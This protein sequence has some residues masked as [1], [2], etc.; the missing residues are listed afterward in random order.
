MGVT[1]G[2]ARQPEEW[3]PTAG[4]SRGTRARIDV[5]GHAFGLRGTLAVRPMDRRDVSLPP[6]YLLAQMGWV[7]Q[8]ARSLLG[9]PYDAEDVAQEV[10]LAASARPP[11]SD[12]NPRAWLSVVTRHLVHSR[13]RAEARRRRRELKVARSGDE[14]RDDDVLARGETSQ[15]LATAVMALEEPYRS[16]VLRRYLDGLSAAEIAAHDGVTEAAV[17]KRLSRAMQQL[18]AQLDKEFEGGRVGWTNA[19]ITVCQG[20]GFELA[21]TVGTALGVFLIMKKVSIVVAAVAV[22]VCVFMFIPAARRWLG[23]DLN[24]G[25]GQA[26][27]ET[28]TA[29]PPTPFTDQGQLVAKDGT[30]ETLLSGPVPSQKS[31]VV[32]GVV[33]N[34][35]YPDPSR[36]PTPAAGVGVTASLRSS[37]PRP[38][39]SAQAQTGADGR[40][41]IELMDPGTRPLE[42]ALAAEGDADY[43]SGRS[44]LQI[45]L[46]TTFSD[47]R[48]ERAARGDLVGVVVDADE[49]PLGG[50][51]VQVGYSSGMSF[52]SESASEAKLNRPD[53]VATTDANGVFAF[54]NLHSAGGFGTP[55]LVGRKSGYRM[56]PMT[57]PS[58]LPKGGWNN[59]RITM[60][61]TGGRI[62]AHVHDDQG[63]PE[64]GA[65]LGITVSNAEPGA[66]WEPWRHEQKESRAHGVTG[67]N[68]RVA[69][70][71]IWIGV[72][73]ELSVGTD[74]ESWTFE[75]AMDGR[76]VA[77]QTE[78]GSPI[79]VPSS[80]SLDLEI[81]LPSHIRVRGRVVDAMGA[82]VPDANIRLSARAPQRDGM[83]SSQPFQCDGGG[84]FE[85]ELRRPSRK[86]AFE[87]NA[88]TGQ[89]RMGPL[90]SLPPEAGRMIGR[91]TMEVA[92][93]SPA[94]LLVLVELQPELTIS[95][96]AREAD[97]NACKGSIAAIPDGA[98]EGDYG[99][100]AARTIGVDGHFE[101]G[102][103]L[104]G[105][106]DLDVRP[107]KN[108]VLTDCLLSQRFSGIA[109]GRGGVELVLGEDQA[110]NVVLEVAPSDGVIGAMTVAT[111]RFYPFQPRESASHA[112][113]REKHFTG[114]SGW[115]P[116]ATLN[117][118]GQTGDINEEGLTS[119]LN[120]GGD[121]PIHRLKPMN[122]GWYSIG[123]D[124]TDAAG[125]HYHPCGTGLVYL[126][127]GSYHF[128]FDLV[129]QTHV[130]GRILNAEFKDDLCVGLVTRDGRAVQVLRTNRHLDEVV[131]IGAR[132]RFS[133]EGAPAG[134]FRLRFGSE[135]QLRAGE[136]DHEVPLAISSKENAPVLIQMP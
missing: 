100:G 92:P 28:A 35:G 48:L 113:D 59:A 112:P 131:S 102:G 78:I 43:R 30:R 82:A 68:G 80:S 4:S 75:R 128:R 104:P 103:L 89:Q 65:Q 94:E 34:L 127:P 39:S 84:V 91:Q 133:I 123:I 85:Q 126:T 33:F 38:E 25:A 53:A 36:A 115:P 63:R 7:R 136:F 95:G 99:R 22:L 9:N 73:L 110:V 8:L 77:Q 51:E 13:G 124:A 108:Y 12:S 106:Y 61:P 41:H 62:T 74:H 135:R 69:L 81:I 23:L 117:F 10:W 16:S 116:G 76:V 88:Y 32:D 79:V 132:G 29:T 114:V 6:N 93:D 58:P 129:R 60:V 86:I 15:R 45:E 66:H 24:Q 3:H 130:E 72:R 11:Q 42:L 98:F 31:I 1:R 97:G 50:V 55:S 125:Q 64:I 19:L 134:E 47:L 5:R 17:R 111:G 21:G 90:A 46:Q 2:G 18:R 101:I 120:M 70:D 83:I 44:N 105:T 119:F 118:G 49:K 54:R 26:I 56:L 87:I 121:V 96:T 27:V 37:R 122:P 52:N 14:S 109:A 67:E 20:S 71:D 40:F 57:P 107:G